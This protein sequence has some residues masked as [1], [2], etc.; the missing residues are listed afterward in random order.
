MHTQYFLQLWGALIN[1]ILTLGRGRHFFT[2]T[3]ALMDEV[4]S[5]L[6]GA[7]VAR[8]PTLWNCAALGLAWQRRCRIPDA[9]CW[10]HVVVSEFAGSRPWRR[11]CDHCL[12]VVE[13]MKVWELQELIH[14]SYQKERTCPEC[15]PWLLGTQV[16]AVR[17]LY[18]LSEPI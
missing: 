7:A 3:H 18:G 1:G 16:L 17:L 5:S 4:A 13:D 11:L 9:L 8:P 14:I 2:A 12:F 6:A 15:R 10:K